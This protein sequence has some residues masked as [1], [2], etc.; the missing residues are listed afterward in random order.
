MVSR[1]AVLAHGWK[2]PRWV[3]MVF[4]WTVLYLYSLWFLQRLSLSPTSL[5]EFS[6]AYLSSSLWPSVCSF[7]RGGS[8][9]TLV[10]T[11]II[12]VCYATTIN[13]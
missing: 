13:D 4:E 6:L 8:H 2:L 1:H 3:E 5:R 7:I 10:R 11:R 9:S 12:F